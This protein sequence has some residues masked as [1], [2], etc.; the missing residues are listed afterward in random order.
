MLIYHSLEPRLCFGKA[1]F[2]LTNTGVDSQGRLNRDCQVGKTGPY[3][4]ESTESPVDGDRPSL[5]KVWNYPSNGEVFFTS[6]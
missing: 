3:D 1:S 4:L 6:Q 2:K 5:G